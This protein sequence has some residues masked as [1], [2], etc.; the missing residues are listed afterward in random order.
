MHPDKITLHRLFEPILLLCL[1]YLPGL[2]Q[3]GS[4]SDFSILNHINYQLLYSASVIPQIILTLYIMKYSPVNSALL[5]DRSCWA[6]YYGLRKPSGRSIIYIPLLL[7]G[8]WIYVLAASA[9]LSHT[10]ILKENESARWVMNSRPAIILFAFTSQL[11]GWSEELFFRGFLLRRA[12]MNSRD[13]IPVLVIVTLLFGVLHIYQGL[14]GFVVT[15]GIGFIFALYYLKTGDLAT[16]A[17]THGLY[18]FTVM[19]LSFSAG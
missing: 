4:F 9:L 18:N 19:L 14:G 12:I 2:L 10:G 11:T 13:T 17:I 3:Q 7:I 6:G 5:P 15:G 8:V 16:A 1:F